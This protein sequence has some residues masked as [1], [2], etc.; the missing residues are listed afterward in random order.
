MP[1]NHTALSQLINTTE[2]SL[3]QFSP[4]CYHMSIIQTSSGEYRCPGYT[5]I[6]SFNPPLALTTISEQ[7]SIFTPDLIILAVNSFTS[8]TPL[9]I[10]GYQFYP[11]TN[12]LDSLFSFKLMSEFKFTNLMRTNS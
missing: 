9:T 5:S 8:K 6:K 7:C 3:T 11:Y 4:I 12:L 2:N 10:W 1:P